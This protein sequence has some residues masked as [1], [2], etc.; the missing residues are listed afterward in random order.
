MHASKMKVTLYE[1]VKRAQPDY[2]VLNFDENMKT[3]YT[4][5]WDCSWHC[6]SAYIYTLGAVSKFGN[7]CGNA[8]HNACLKTKM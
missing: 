6:T 7:F 1:Q 2:Q 3:H 8:M 4:N 5:G